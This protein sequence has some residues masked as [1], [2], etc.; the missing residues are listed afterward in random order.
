MVTSLAVA[1]VVPVPELWTTT[2]RTRTTTM[3]GMVHAF[4]RCQDGPT[5]TQHIMNGIGTCLVFGPD[6][7]AYDCC[8][9]CNEANSIAGQYMP[10]GGKD[11]FTGFV[12]NSAACCCFTGGYIE[13]GPD[14]RAG[15]NGTVYYMEPVL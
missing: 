13:K 10:P 11:A 8:K 14:Q 9:L 1:L 12:H 15:V 7:S 3:I 2:T 5:E 4:L 6:E